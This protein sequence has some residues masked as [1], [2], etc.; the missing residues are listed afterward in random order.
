MRLWRIAAFALMLFVPMIASAQFKD[1]DSA[2][3]NLSRGF[4]QGQAQ[5]IIE[6]MAAGDQ[7]QLQFP[8]LIDKSGF[9]GRD[10]ASYLLDEL[11]SKARPSGFQRVSAQKQ[12][13]EAQYH[14]T[15]TWTIQPDGK[16]QERDLYITLGN[17]N[18]RW[19]IVSIRAAGK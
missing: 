2:M 6:G 17:K 5:P 1:L 15:A 9:F 4:E 16:Q 7:V 3:S 8:G 13:A 19:S 10:Q 11:F 18:D 14:I 12:S